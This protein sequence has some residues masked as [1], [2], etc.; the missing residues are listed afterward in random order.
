[1]KPS[2]FAQLQENL[3]GD[4][5]ETKTVVGLFFESAQEQ[6]QQLHTAQQNADAARLAYA[7]HQL[8]GAA[9]TC[10]LEKLS[11]TLRDLEQLATTTADPAAW[12]QTLAMADNEINRMRQAWDETLHTQD[13]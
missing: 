8:A 6:L 4:W 5:N 12:S 7:A 1:M 9:G 13:T 11:T 2:P 3:G 10:G